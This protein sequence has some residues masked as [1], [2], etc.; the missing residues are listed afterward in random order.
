MAILHRDYCQTYQYQTQEV[1]EALYYMTKHC[2]LYHK[3]FLSTANTWPART[4]RTDCFK[5]LCSKVHLFQNAGLIQL[6]NS[7]ICENMKDLHILK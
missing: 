4:I 6:G 3:I 5:R 1:V 2:E 7:L